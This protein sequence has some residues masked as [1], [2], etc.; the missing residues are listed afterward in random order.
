VL[1]L[2]ATMYG[3]H[4]LVAAT[5][6]F[7]VLSNLF[8]VK[9]ITLFGL[10]ATAADAFAVGALLGLN[11]LQEF[12]GKE[13]TRKTI[14]LNFI[15]LIVYAIFA[16]LHLWFTPAA[17]DINQ[18]HFM[19]ILQHAPRIVIASIAAYFLAQVFDY[20]FY[21]F[22]RR[23]TNNKFYLM[24]TYIAVIASQLVDTV[25]FGVLALYGIV[26]N[27]GQIILV[28]YVVKLIVIAIATPLV[29]IAKK[30]IRV[31]A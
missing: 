14:A 25:L 22:L 17:A 2:G 11:V 7:G 4:G 18:I 15:C 6:L 29:T 10:T 27:L 13:I 16:Q 28:S 5:C 26:E 31:Q 20:F 9:Q 30:F 19:G 1:T 12:Y 3:T 24:R 21:G 8:V 23:I